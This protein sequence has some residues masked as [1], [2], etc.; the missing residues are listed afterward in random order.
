MC[1]CGQRLPAPPVKQ[2][3]RPSTPQ[4]KNPQQVIITA[5]N[6]PDLTGAERVDLSAWGKQAILGGSGGYDD[7]NDGGSL[8]AAAGLFDSSTWTQNMVGP[9]SGE[10]EDIWTGDGYDS[11]NT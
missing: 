3:L 10:G 7:G 4:S 2:R 1:S 6:P 9:T 11:F 8:P 5:A